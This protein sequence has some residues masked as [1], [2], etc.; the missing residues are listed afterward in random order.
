MKTKNL[1]FEAVT[2][3]NI[4]LAT[5]IELGFFPDMCAYCSYEDSFNNNNVY[6]IVY[7][8][9][10]IVGI[11]GIYENANLGEPKTCWMGWFGVLPEK[12]RHGYGK[13][14]LD[15]T[16][17]IAKEKGYDTLRLYTSATLCPE[18][19][20]FYDLFMDFGENYT[21]EETDLERKVYTKSLTRK[22]ATKWNNRKLYLDHEK[23]R[24]DEGMK[25]YLLNLKKK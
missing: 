6:W 17:E 7:D 4:N 25:K 24:E 3:E 10:E 12:R 11:C 18:A 23:N 21:L 20:I 19:I 9:N 13:A 16:I 5:K 14:I 1:R 22:P 8:E 2:P 15:K